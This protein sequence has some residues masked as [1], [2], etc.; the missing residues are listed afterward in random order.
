MKR[1]FL[2]QTKMI[3]AVLLTSLLSSSR[4]DAQNQIGGPIQGIIPGMSYAEDCALSSDG[5]RIIV[6]MPWN[7]SYK[8]VVRVFRL[9]SGAWTQMGADIPGVNNNDRFGTAVDI[10]SDGNTI[11]ASATE[12]D[13]PAGIPANNNVGSVRIFTWS[14]SAWVQK[15]STI[16]GRAVGDL[17][18]D[19]IAM[20][21]SGNGFIVGLENNN[22]FK[23]DDG[24]A[25]VYRWNGTAWVQRG[26]DVVLPASSNGDFLGNAVDISTDGNRIA[27]GAVG[28]DP[29]PGF[30]LTGSAAVFQW[31]NTT[32]QWNQLGSR[33]LGV[34]G[35]ERFGHRLGLSYSGDT[36]IVGAFLYSDSGTR[37][38]VTR[39]YEY[40]S[41]L[42]WKQ[43][44]QNIAG[45][46][47]GDSS[48]F[49]VAISDNGRVI[50][51]GAPRNDNVAINA[52]HV[53]IYKNLGANWERA[54][55][56]DINGTTGGGVLNNPN[57]QWFG[58]TVA[59]NRTGNNRLAA[60]SG[61]AGVYRGIVRVFTTS[62]TYC[63]DG[64]VFWDGG[65]ADN[66]WSTRANWVGD[67]CPCEGADV[68]FNTTSKNCVILDTIVMSSI[69]T[70]NGFKNRI[71]MQGDTARLVV[72][73]LSIVGNVFEVVRVPDS[74]A[75]IV[76]SNLTISDNAQMSLASKG[77][78]V[79][80]V[81]EVNGGARFSPR[82]GSTINLNNLFLNAAGSFTSPGGNGVVNLSGYFR[83]GLSVSFDAT[84]TTWN[85]TGAATHDMSFNTST[86]TTTTFTKLNISNA[87]SFTPD[88][89]ILTDSFR[90]IGSSSN[91]TGGIFNAR[92]RIIVG[93]SNNTMTSL[94]IGGA[95][96][97]Q[98]LSCSSAGALSGTPVIVN[99]TTS[100][101]LVLGSDVSFGTLTLT[102]GHIDPNGNKATLTSNSI[103]GASN[104]S[105]IIGT[106]YVNKM[107]G[108]FSGNKIVVP[109]GNG[110][111]LKAIVVGNN[112]GKNDW[113]IDY[114]GS[115][116]SGVDPDLHSSLSSISGVEYWS[117][118][119]LT[120]DSSTYFGLP[121][122]GSFDR[123]AWLTSG[124]WR[125]IGGTTSSGVI[126]ST[127]NN[128]FAST[129]T[130]LLTQGVFNTPPPAPINVVND[131]D[132]VSGTEVAL[133]KNSVSNQV[134]AA[135]NAAAL[136]VYPNPARTSIQ[137]VMPSQA[138]TF[139]VSDMAGRLVGT[140]PAS[141]R[142][143]DLS[144][145]NNGMYL[146][147]TEV[148]GTKQ[149]ILFVKH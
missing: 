148:N 95:T 74:K 138:V 65:G 38:G 97:N 34:T 123:V 52:G 70:T 135:N 122:A 45:E 9:V 75:E 41:S 33:L 7:S 85:M 30:N 72:G 140:Y 69:T 143:L 39:I 139:H 132:M 36:L 92:S 35:G 107:N 21:G 80:G 128:L 47:N 11:I 55:T 130:Y 26:Q 141:V 42:I 43:V 121:A 78:T 82:S 99:K 147:T 108:A 98:T 118:Q 134:N 3:A 16:Y 2:S 59:L 101:N 4:A 103:S 119:R 53:R 1:K 62:P 44:G 14:G 142:Q 27:V 90:I 114:I 111:S 68:V 66:L 125:S 94:T 17:M 86:V 49:D 15:G 131:K 40:N 56:E 137:V 76:C 13:N 73:N 91:V 8:G 71:R 113:K 100:G 31:N 144:G 20:D 104:A 149:S 127:E 84:G 126:T 37:K 32:S 12:S 120:A 18:G 61:E 117:A 50:A 116:P 88:N 24:L 6:G 22:N 54:E 93:S 136:S 89:I 83:R 81:M 146:I 23:V 63:M 19:A 48:G 112:G 57:N 58:R 133:E 51:I 106:A 5:T 110:G 115:N 29:I 25:L 46:A 109:V 60:G 79:T 64:Q 10:S 87:C 102:K 28:Y 129:G 105:Y 124:S 96:G 145:L 77:I 67:K